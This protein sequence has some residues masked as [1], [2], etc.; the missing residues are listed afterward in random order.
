[1]TQ[2]PLI[3]RRGLPSVPPVPEATAS[4]TSGEVGAPEAGPWQAYRDLER[5]AAVTAVFDRHHAQ[6]VRLATLLGADGDAEDIVADAFCELYR[7][8]HRLREPEAA[9]AYVRS[10]VCNLVRMRIRHLQVV[11]R[12]PHLPVAEGSPEQQAVLREDHRDVVTALQKLP[13]RQ[14]EALVLRYY[15]D[16]KEVEVA[17]S[18]GI[19]V[20]AVKSHTA[21]GMAAMTRMLEERQ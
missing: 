21:R 20:G 1:M 15:L 3:P 7:R 10:T 12:H 8:W 11:R 5:E 16:L 19:S 17:A 4:A 2:P 9:P 13:E 14:R 18:M 6:L